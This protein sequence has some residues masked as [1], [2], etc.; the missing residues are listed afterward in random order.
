MTRTINRPLIG[1]AVHIIVHDYISY[2]YDTY[3]IYLYSRH[4]AS[5]LYFWLVHIEHQDY[6][7]LIFVLP[8]TYSRWG[9]ELQPCSRR[10]EEA[11]R[12]RK[13]HG[14]AAWIG[15][16]RE[17]GVVR[18]EGKRCSLAAAHTASAAD[19]W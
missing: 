10:E 3:T 7:E 14:H 4:R 16:G 15:T 19:G 11:A 1:L 6:I 12:N 5:R 8:W 9:R 13:M 18:M 17:G 2:M